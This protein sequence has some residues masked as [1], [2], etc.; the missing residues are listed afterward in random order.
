MSGTIIDILL[1][2]FWR[3]IRLE[4]MPKTPQITHKLDEIQAEIK[5][6]KAQ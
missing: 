3:L 5:R 1:A 6:L 4:D 2:E